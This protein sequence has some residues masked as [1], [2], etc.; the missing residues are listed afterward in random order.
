MF[1]TKSLPSS[2][3]EKVHQIQL[4]DI[5]AIPI[6]DG[7]HFSEH[8]E[9]QYIENIHKNNFYDLC[10]LHKVPLS[11]FNKTLSL[12]DKHKINIFF[13]ILK[14]RNGIRIMDSLIYLEERCGRF[15][16]LINCIDEENQW[17]LK[18]E[19]SELSEKYKIVTNRL[20]DFMEFEKK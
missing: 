20:K 10:K 7:S 3:E 11:L 9:T 14:Q 12:K 5:R 1:K 8:L 13:R 15:N 4:E 19:A 6:T 17:T 16:Q 2:K 18:I